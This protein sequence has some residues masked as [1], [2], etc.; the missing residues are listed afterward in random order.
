MKINW[1]NKIKNRKKENE[2]IILAE[3]TCL[4]VRNVSMSFSGLK[5]V[6]DVSFDIKEG[7]IFGLIGPNGAGKTTLFNCI[8]Q[9]YK[10]DNG[11]IF[12]R[13]N[14]NETINL[15][16]FPTHKIIR[17]GLVR[18]FQNVELIG[19]LSVIENVMVGAHIKY[20]YDFWGC[21][22]GFSGAK[23]EEKRIEEEAEGV[24][25][26]I[27]LDD[28]KN[29][30]VSSQPYGILKK[31]ELARA[32][33]CNPKLIIL[34]EPAAGMNEAET[35]ELMNMI[36]IIRD[37]YKTTILL[38]EHD[39]KLVMGICDR[40]CAISF[41]E[42]IAIGTPSQIKNNIKVQEAYLGVTK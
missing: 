42:V 29:Q 23:K 12:F 20:K 2:Q 31:I 22:F 40:I 39:M 5:V 34:D 15:I 27:G 26:F 1:I 24:L 41:G 7:E 19:D 10:P 36:K 18:T 3:D 6:T 28:I 9:F 35:K 30:P 37:E 13:N 11:S 25:K 8:T 38:V 32:L 16:N 17:H 14:K 21:L 33:M 4:S